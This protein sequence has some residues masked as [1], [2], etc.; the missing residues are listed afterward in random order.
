MD[1]IY[2]LILIALGALAVFDLMVGVSNDAVNFL[3][4]AIGSK[5]F[6]L[7]NIMI[8]A[9]I[10]IFLGASTSSGMM[11]VARK[12]IFVPSQFYF[13]EIM[14]IFMAVMITDILLLDFFNTIGIPT[15]TTVS[16]VF[17]LLG[18]A[19]FMSLIKISVSSTETLADLGTYINSAKALQIIMGI[20]L[21]VFI[22]F[23][24]GTIVQFLSRLVYT[25]QY[26]KKKTFINPIFFGIAI[27]SISFFIFFKGLKGTSYYGDV[28][29]LLEGKEAFWLIGSLALWSLIGFIIEK[30][31][32]I[33][34]LKIIIALGTFS[35]A[36][37]FAG[38]DLVNFIGVPMAALSSYKAWVASGVPADQ[39]SMGILA[40]K[41][42]TQ[43]FLLFL[44]GGIMVAT[45]WLSKKARNVAE[46]EI[47]LAR[48]GE[49]SEKFEA[50]ILSKM[51]VRSATV[52]TDVAVK[53]I[54]QP[55]LAFI[56]KRFEKPVVALPL[57]KTHELPAFDMIRASINLVLAGILISIATSYK[58]PL[59]TT[60]VTF[61]VAMGTSLADKAWGLESAVY[62]V[63]GL[64]NVI[65]GWFMTAVI[66]FIVSGIFCY[67]IY[68]GEIVSIAVLLAI[69]AGIII[70]NTLRFHQK[71]KEAEEKLF[72][73]RMNLKNISAVVEDS[74]DHI[75]K[76]VKHSNKLYTN[77]VI[78]LSNHDLNKLKR[79]QKHVEKLE[80][81][82]DELNNEVFYYIKTLEDDSV[83]ASRFYILI[84]SYIQNISHSI[85]YISTASFRHVDNNHKKLKKKQIAELQSINET[86]NDLFKEI[87]T[88]F[89]A[90]DFSHLDDIIN[91]KRSLYQD[92][93]NL[94][95]KQI[96]RVRSE[97]SSPKN[98][99]LFFGILLETRE[100]V[101]SV[102]NV[103]KL[104]QAFHLKNGK[105]D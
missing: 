94:I 12:G 29:H 34:L 84:L 50:N 18:A 11:E 71:K 62:R 46:T 104:F 4:S 89:K 42:P 53:F 92:L 48:Q 88:V 105:I 8:I 74:S 7:R 85:K 35:L 60:Y 68:L 87:E 76:V 67:L 5:A 63:A 10:G 38:N 65:G 22:A 15:S 69:V 55:A 28:K 101:N 14:F 19:V 93:E 9:S 82:T 32:K 43:N 40:E 73:K 45:L 78:D 75:S 52:F 2:I 23:T 39:F 58:L 49:G 16:I 3:N 102:V 97:D 64:F 57:D 30:V 24:T 33:D 37:A 77:V 31:S 26:E 83:E 41:V 70:N 25:F 81:E 90:K 96:E 86:L 27:S 61:M 44:A 95:N 51:V 21:S 59:S 13:K 20:L 54:P 17:E 72:S 6:S 98:T 56:G 1:N 91:K 99:T 103:I 47:N 80:K 79:N 36:L 66:A 100:L